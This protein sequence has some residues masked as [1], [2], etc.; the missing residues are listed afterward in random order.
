VGELGELAQDLD[1]VLKADLGG[2]TGAVG[3]LGEAD[4][5]ALHGASCCG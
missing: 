1:Q 2:S 4:F 3:E 5:A